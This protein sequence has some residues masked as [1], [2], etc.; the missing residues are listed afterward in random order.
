MKFSSFISRPLTE[1]KNVG[2]T[3]EG[4]FAI[5]VALHMAYGRIDKSK[6]HQIRK[7][8]D[9][10]SGKASYVIDPNIANDNIYG[11]EA[12]SSDK[13]SV[14]VEV[15][16]RPNKVDGMFGP[17]MVA[18]PAVDSKIETLVNKVPNLK[19]LRKIHEFM[20]GVLTN[21]KKD[22]IDFTV[23]ADGGAGISS[24][25]T[26]KGDI[27]LKISAKSKTDIPKDLSEPIVFSLKTDETTV[28]NMGIFDGMLKLG[29]LFNLSF[30]EGL[31]KLDKFPDKYSKIQDI[32]YQHPE[33]MDDDNHFL[34]YVRKYLTIQ[35]K[36][37]A[38]GG[39]YE[40]DADRKV[41]QAGQ[42]LNQLKVTLN[43]FIQA[44]SEEIQAK[45]SEVFTADPRARVFT[46][47]CFEFLRGA[48][49]GSDTPRVV[50]I[51]GNDIKEIEDADFDQ[52]KNEY[53]VNLK[54]EPNG[55]MKFY[56]ININNESKLLFQIRPRLEYNL[57]S[58]KKTQ[59]LIVE[60]GEL[61]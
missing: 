47:K 38:G 43:R 12:D 2:E 24:G 9:L 51:R 44:M 5:A 16:L 33:K 29:Q 36:H 10:S 31:E 52:L 41:G 3:M 48:I 26:I 49:F 27:K 17:K 54:T 4:I 15:Y 46:M 39:D 37:Y 53:V 13:V 61:I 7:S 59:K 18:Y 50:S 30:I 55:T 19:I 32:I 22:D 35:D 20:I 14:K 8:L 23:V 28:S 42:E 1:E 60:V 25:G 11:V 21:H 58:G 56:G 45:D 57:K 6:L 40:S 34:S